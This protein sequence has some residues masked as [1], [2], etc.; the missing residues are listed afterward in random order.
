MTPVAVTVTRH[1]KKRVHERLGLPSRAVVRAAARALRSGLSSQDVGNDLRRYLDAKAGQ[2]AELFR[3][4]RG[5]VFAFAMVGDTA[6]LITAW[7][8]KRDLQP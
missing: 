4:Y 1:A 7:P 3:V 8:L 5:A 6:A 2:N